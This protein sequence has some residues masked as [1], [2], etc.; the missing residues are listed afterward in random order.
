MP[1]EILIKYALLEIFA[2]VG[3]LLLVYWLFKP[4]YINPFNM[5]KPDE[6]QRSRQEDARFE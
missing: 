6:D 5:P 2:F 3:L 1:I 4:S